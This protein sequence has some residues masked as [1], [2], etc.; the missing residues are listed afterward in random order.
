MEVAPVD[1]SSFWSKLLFKMTVCSFPGFDTEAMHL[2]LESFPAED[3]FLEDAL[4]IRVALQLLLAWVLLVFLHIV[5]QVYFDA[6]AV[7][8][9]PDLIKA[10]ID[11][12]FKHRLIEGR[13]MMQHDFSL[14]LE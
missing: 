4:Q 14:P 7:H 6:G 5:M 8:S 10:K 12:L 3:A 1:E 9:L 11:I 13:Q 2:V